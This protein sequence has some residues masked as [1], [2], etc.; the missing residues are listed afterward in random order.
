MT[1]LSFQLTFPYV[2]TGAVHVAPWSVDFTKTTLK[3]F[4]YSA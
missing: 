3:P 2:L 1:G 4:M